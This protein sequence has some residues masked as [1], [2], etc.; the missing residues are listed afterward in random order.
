MKFEIGAMSI[1]DMLDRGLKLLWAR[2]GTFY[3]ITLIMLLPVLIVRLLTPELLFPNVPEPSEHMTPEEM[4]RV[5]EA[6]LIWLGQALAVIFLELLLTLLA[7]AATLHVTAGEYVDRHV[8]FAEAFGHVFRR[9]GSLLLASLLAWLIIGL[10]TVLFIVP[11]LMFLTWFVFVPQVVVLEGASPTSALARSAELSAGF[12]WRIL[13]MFLLLLVINI[14]MGLVSSL[15]SLLFPP[16]EIV[17]GPGNT[18]IQIINQTNYFIFV[19]VA[20]LIQ[21]V[22]HSYGI[23]CWTLFYFDL[24][25]RKEGFDLELM[26]Q[27]GH[28]PPAG[29]PG[30]QAGTVDGNPPD[31]P[32]PDHRD[33][34]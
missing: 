3:A 2:F 27:P 26:A 20:Y 8:G 1:G 17:R 5:L 24:R 18:Q 15:T 11:G 33:L 30:I 6:M 21:M 7:T 22:S 16:A 28:S 25:I 31:T 14:G 10:G 9:S 13:G 34:F 12:R 4:E 32:G 19:I 29:L 23:V